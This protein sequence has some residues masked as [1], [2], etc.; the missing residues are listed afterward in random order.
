M[1]GNEKRKSERIRLTLTLPILEKEKIIGQLED[2]THFGVRLTCSEE[3]KASDVYE[4]AIELP[5]G[6]EE[7][8]KIVFSATCMWCTIDD[9]ISMYHAG[10]QFKKADIKNDTIIGQLIEQY[11]AG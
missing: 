3:L 1:I 6:F 2:I 9:T 8:D 10:F 11:A 7:G 4:L 5:E